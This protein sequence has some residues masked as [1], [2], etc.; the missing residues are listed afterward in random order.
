VQLGFYLLTFSTDASRY[1]S[2]H[3]LYFQDWAVF[4]RFFPFH[5]EW[6]HFCGFLISS[7][8][9]SN[10]SD[11][12]SSIRYHLHSLLT[13]SK[14]TGSATLPIYLSLKF[15]KYRRILD[16]LEVCTFVKT[17]WSCLLLL[18]PRLLYRTIA[19]TFAHSEVYWQ[20]LHI[21]QILMHI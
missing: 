7:R 17:W 13:S 12:D 21:G 20:L 11:P 19:F 10:W 2:H 3:L 9:N 5:R 4:Q 18:L 8:M 15:T 6:K 16:L 1:F 14:P